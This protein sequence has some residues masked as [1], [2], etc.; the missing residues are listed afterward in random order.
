MTSTRE[1]NKQQA[2]HS[3][4]II[5]LIYIVSWF[6]NIVVYS[7]ML[8]LSMCKMLFTSKHLILDVDA[9]TMLYVSAYNALVMPVSFSINPVVYFWRSKLYRSEMRRVL[10][11][12]N[13]VSSV[14][15]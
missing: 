9:M 6:N 15:K 8:A 3:L 12:K 5:V 7:A 13:A 11:F 10:G 4:A 1:R 14:V 2:L